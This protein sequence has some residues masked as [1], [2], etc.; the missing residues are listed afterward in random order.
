MG[1]ASNIE[2]EVPFRLK[3]IALFW[4]TACFKTSGMWEREEECS[5]SRSSNSLLRNEELI[6]IMW[7]LIM[8]LLSISEDR[9]IVNSKI[10]NF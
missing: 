8:A 1:I 4:K 5:I 6:V 9:R 7:A 3:Y 2:I 10:V